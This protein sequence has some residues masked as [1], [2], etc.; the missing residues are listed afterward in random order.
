MIDYCDCAEFVIYVQCTCVYLSVL[1]NTQGLLVCLLVN[2][3]DHL[4]DEHRK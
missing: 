1:L 4:F 2:V 3:T